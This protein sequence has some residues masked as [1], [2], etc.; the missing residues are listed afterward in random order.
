MRGKL[1]PFF[2]KCSSKE[3]NKSL[4][5]DDGE[6]SFPRDGC[7]QYA[8]FQFEQTCRKKLKGVNTNAK[9]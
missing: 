4:C 3:K 8:I 2:N 6:L 7:P 1:C 5:I 9:N